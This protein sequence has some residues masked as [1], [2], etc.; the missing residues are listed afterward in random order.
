VGQWGGAT[1]VKAGSIWIVHSV[2]IS[3]SAAGSGTGTG[4]GLTR[5]QADARY[6]LL[7]A[8]TSA[9]S[10]VTK[11]TIGLGNVDN[12][13][14]I[15]KPVSTAVAA[16]LATKANASS[17]ITVSS[18]GTITLNASQGNYQ[19]ITATGNVV[20]APPT[21]PA[22]QQGMR[23]EVYAPS[24]STRTVTTTGAI[25]NAS[26]LTLPLTIQSGRFAILGLVYSARAGRWM[27]LSYT[28]EP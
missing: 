12:T 7:G 24:G 18:G 1:F 15:N 27:L 6:D 16:A 9:V 8:A 23:I 19:A 5:E 22:D 13:S 28:V 10:A 3:Y 17:V 2:N 14:D 26:G 20:L 25:S 11:S 21:S 4:T